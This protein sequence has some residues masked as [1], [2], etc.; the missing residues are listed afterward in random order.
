M[1]K[2]NTVTEA[3]HEIAATSLQHDGQKSTN[4]G[5][6]EA[7]LDDEQRIRERMRVLYNEYA[8]AEQELSALQDTRFRVCI[9]GSARISPND[10]TYKMVYLLAKTLGKLGIDIVTGGGP[11]LMEAANQGLKD[12][13]E[14]GIYSIGLP[15][16]LP[17]RKEISNS[18]LDIKNEHN[19]FSTRL[20][21]F[22][23]LSHAVIVAP[24]GI[25]TLLELAYTW[26]LVQVEMI[27][28]RAVILLGTE[29]W[30]GLLDWMRTHQ[31]KRRFVEPEDLDFVHLADTQAEVLSYIC[32]ELE[33][34]RTKLHEA[35][36]HPLAQQAGAILEH[37]GKVKDAPEHHAPLPG[38]RQSEE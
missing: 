34:F 23:L 27:A 3:N 2:T 4:R 7:T 28:P 19:R 31:L 21:E 9:F 16:L 36:N 6:S 30:G 1:R 35:G 37:V 22:I 26:Q 32:P 25:G 8:R 14:E 20:D 15:I 11:G 33:K 13:H 12:A 17:H 38:L 24:G 10:P 29:F 5:E 18:H